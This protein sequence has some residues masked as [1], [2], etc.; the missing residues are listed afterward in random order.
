MFR[1][2]LWSAAVVRFQGVWYYRVGYSMWVLS[3]L[4]L[5]TFILLYSTVNSTGS[6]PIGVVKKRFYRS[7]FVGELVQY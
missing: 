4:F 7:G 5:D 1:F 6:R 2:S 3:E